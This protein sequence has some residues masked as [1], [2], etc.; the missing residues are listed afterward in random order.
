MTAIM[1]SNQVADHL[2]LLFLKDLKKTKRGLELVSLPRVIH[3]FCRKTFVLL[4][5]F[6]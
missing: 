2:L 3:G 1:Y 6:N 5:S 4:N